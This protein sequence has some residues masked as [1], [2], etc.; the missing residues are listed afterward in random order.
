MSGL[1]TAKPV[2]DSVLD[3][4][5]PSPAGHTNSSGA[6]PGVFLQRVRIKHPFG[7]E[8]TAWEG[9][10]NQSDHWAA[11]WDR[12][13]LSSR[14]NWDLRFQT[15]DWRRTLACGDRL[16]LHP[17]RCGDRVGHDDWR[18]CDQKSLIHRF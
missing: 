2:L 11:P 12:G 9:A 13:G 10:V 3:L 14:S 4:Y 1:T 7:F 8:S 16:M 15:F 6:E 18:K 17:F 5:L